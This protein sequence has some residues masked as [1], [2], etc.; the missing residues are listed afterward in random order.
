MPV[1]ARKTTTPTRDPGA[2]F[3]SV[4]IETSPNL[5]QTSLD[6]CEALNAL[7]A[8]AFA[9]YL[10]TKNFQW[11]V[12]GPHFRD[13]YLLFEEQAMQ[14][15]P[16]TDAIA[17]RVRKNG[18]RTLR[19]IGHIARV[20]RLRDNDRGLVAPPQML[21]ELT[22]DNAALA[23]SLEEAHELSEQQ[24]DVA[25]ARLIEGWIDEAQNRVWFLREANG[26]SGEL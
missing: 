26:A 8:D 4:P 24:R 25:T 3:V 7:I 11:H 23:R 12:S 20:Q 15:L 14:I 1:T 17:E 2:L 22:F 13:Y 9:L 16:M 10:K 5:W 19:S 21:G 18:A 6:L